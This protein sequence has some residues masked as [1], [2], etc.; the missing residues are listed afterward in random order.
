MRLRRRTRRRF[1]AEVAG[2]GAGA[3]VWPGLV[4]TLGVE[5]APHMKFP[6]EARERIAIAS[7]PFRDFVAGRSDES[8]GGKM[9]L[10]EFAAHVSVKFN[11]K[12]IEPWS[13]HFR[14]LDE[15]YLKE[16]RE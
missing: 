1:L 14:M 3:L 8:G 2:A 10:K 7:Y 16:F 13:E 11:I 4:K 15:A 12:K 5:N 6:G 9:E